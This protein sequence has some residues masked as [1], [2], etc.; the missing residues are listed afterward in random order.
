MLVD[1]QENYPK[2]QNLRTNGAWHRSR[3]LFL[4]FGCSCGN[5]I[6]IEISGPPLYRWNGWAKA[7][8]FDMQFNYREYFRTGDI[9]KLAAF[10]M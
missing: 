9:K 4:N 5:V 10:D 6:Y 2:L 3:D 7:I 8:N 1:Y